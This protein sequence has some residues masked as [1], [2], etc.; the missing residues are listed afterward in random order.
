MITAI[1][2]PAPPTTPAGNG[3]AV[4][5]ELARARR[6]AGPFLEDKHRAAA[7]AWPALGPTPL[8]GCAPSRGVRKQ[9][10]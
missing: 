8:R 9:P 4:P 3:Q 10:P 5:G 2:E 1:G 6:H 7:K